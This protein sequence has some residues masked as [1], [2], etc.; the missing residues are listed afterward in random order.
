MQSGGEDIE[1]ELDMKKT[2]GIDQLVRDYSP[3][4]TEE[5]KEL[6]SGG[7]QFSNVLSAFKECADDYK[8]RTE[9]MRQITDVLSPFQIN[10][11]LYLA[12]EGIRKAAYTFTAGL[13]ANR[14]IQNAYE[15]GHSGFILNTGNVPEIN[16]LGRGLKAERERRLS[17]EIRGPVGDGFG[18]NSCNVDFTI[19]SPMDSRY[20]TGGG[21]MDCTFSTSNLDTLFCFHS[22][23]ICKRGVHSLNKI[24]YIHEDGSKR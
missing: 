18:I 20:R 7:D 9:R 14:L 11:F 21:A 24:F 8:T 13:F 12:K 1:M 23:I 4:K 3:G 6:I 16:D 10:A 2:K 17:L 22:Q 19:H 15:S 5:G